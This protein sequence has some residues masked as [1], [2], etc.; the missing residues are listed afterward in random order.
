MTAWGVLLVGVGLGCGM[1]MRVG[2]GVLLLIPRRRSRQDTRRV[3]TNS[4]DVSLIRL[5]LLV[6]E[7]LPFHSKPS[8]N[9]KNSLNAGSSDSVLSFFGDVA[10]CGWLSVMADALRLCD[11]A[12]DFKLEFERHICAS[13]PSICRSPFRVFVLSLEEML[14]NARERRASILRVSRQSLRRGCGSNYVGV[15]IPV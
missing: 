9:L 2:G 15:E 6:V 7:L 14:S 12:D 3:A 1:G 13:S 11:A 4:R 10:A 5:G 8:C